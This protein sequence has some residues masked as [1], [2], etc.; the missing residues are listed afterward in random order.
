M[1][2]TLP[3]KVLQLRV[4][5]I[6]K[7]LRFQLGTFTEADGHYTLQVFIRPPADSAVSGSK[8]FEMLWK[9]PKNWPTEPLDIYFKTPLFHPNIYQK[10]TDDW[11]NQLCHEVMSCHN[12]NV[13]LLKIIQAVQIVL[14]E[15]NPA[16]PANV[17]A[18][19]FFRE[20]PEELFTRLEQDLET[21]GK[22]E[23]EIISLQADNLEEENEPEEGVEES[24]TKYNFKGKKR[25]QDTNTSGSSSSDKRRV[26]DLCDSD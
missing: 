7:N 18:A 22:T 19:K 10:Y 3:K 25:L 13:G 20:T 2:S 9:I 26:V 21:H 1:T 11:G 17:D 4:D 23:L 6:D 5:S 24:K 12:S 15:P 8:Y 14:I 16:S